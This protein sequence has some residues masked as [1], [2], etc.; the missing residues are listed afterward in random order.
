MLSQFTGAE[1]TNKR[2]L[3]EFGFPKAVYPVG[4]LDYDSEGLLILSDDSSLNAALL[5][6]KNRHWRTYLVQVERVPGEEALQKLRTGVIIDGEKTLPARV[7]LI[8]SETTLPEREIPIRFRKSV[9]TC[10]LELS[11]TEGRNRQVRRMTAS[12]GHPTLRLFRRS[13]GK[14]DLLKSDIQ[15]GRWTGLNRDEVL[16]LFGDQ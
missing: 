7:N 16:A 9:P 13:I 15:P 10:W 14:F 3:A 8:E 12:V 2:T 6:P 1:E 4:R 11:L 5:S